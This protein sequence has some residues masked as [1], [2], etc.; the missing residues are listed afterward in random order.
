VLGGGI[1]AFAAA[2]AFRRALPD[3]E[4]TLFTGSDGDKARP[5]YAGAATPYIHHFHRLVGIEPGAFRRRTG[6][7]TVS[8]AEIR[9]TGKPAFRLVPLSEVP[10]VDRAALHQLWLRWTMSDPSAGPAWSDVARRARRQDELTQGLGVRFDAHAYLALLRDLAAHLGLKIAGEPPGRNLEGSF[11]LVIEADEGEVPE[12]DWRRIDGIPGHFPWSVRPPRA[13]AEAVETLEIASDRVT[14]DTAAWQVAG[15][16]AAGM[17][18]AGRVIAPWRANVLAVGRAAVRCE[19]FDG[20]PLAVALAGIVR[21]L[22]LLPRPGAPGRETAEYNRRSGAVHDFLLDWAAE[23]WGTSDT[24]PAGLAALR[25]QFAHRGRIPLRDEDPVPAGH[26]TG[27]LLGRGERPR[28][29]DL[30]AM[31][32]PEERLAAIFA[33]F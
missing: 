28:H 11:D 12:A 13:G 27:W 24:V 1:A 20:Q 17:G 29:I 6:A 8:E 4:V 26:W 10:Y 3:A 7:V 23:R 25:E 31:A 18:A 21:A 5:E 2:A 15:A 16:P 33:G 22:E 9:R 30:T 14:W 32:V 19:T